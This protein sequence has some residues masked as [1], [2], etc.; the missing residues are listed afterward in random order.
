MTATAKQVQS[1][2]SNLSHHGGKDRIRTKRIPLS[3]GIFSWSIF[4]MFDQ[5]SSLKDVTLYTFTSASFQCLSVLR[6]Q[7]ATIANISL[8]IGSANDWPPA[9]LRSF[10]K[11]L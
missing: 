3:K 6:Y 4:K 1:F 8:E 9:Q 10:T 7:G 5:T 11:P 2:A